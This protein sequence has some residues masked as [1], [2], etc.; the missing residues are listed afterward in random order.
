MKIA[1]CVK[2]APD[3]STAWRIDPASGRL[4]RTGDLGLSDVD[5]HAVEE[6]LRV[7]EAS[8]EG[9]VVVVSLG[10]VGAGDASGEVRPS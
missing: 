1:V 8:G 5:L 6:A 3:A 10:P 2:A 9:E 4:D 7:R